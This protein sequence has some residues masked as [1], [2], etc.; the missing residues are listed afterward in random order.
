MDERKEQEA[1]AMMGEVAAQVDASQSLRP[2]KSLR[3]R[4]LRGLTSGTQDESTFVRAYD[5]VLLAAATAKAHG[6]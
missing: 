3:S 2:P 4:L 6:K 1:I 5:A